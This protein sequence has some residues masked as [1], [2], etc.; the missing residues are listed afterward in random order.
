M[1]KHNTNHK[2]KLQELNLNLKNEIINFLNIKEIFSATFALNKNFHK[3]TNENNFINYI[4]LHKTELLE[5]INFSF[6][7]I[8]KIKSKFLN[9]S[10]NEI[11]LDQICSFLLCLKYKKEKN[12]ELSYHHK[13]LKILCFFIEFK[14]NFSFLQISSI[15][16]G[17]NSE[18]FKYFSHILFSVNKTL[19]FINLSMNL[20]RLTENNFKFFCEEF[21][22]NKNIQY[23][24]LSYNN[25]GSET[26]YLKYL[27][28]AIAE[29]TSLKSIDL[30][31]NN[32]GGK[33]EQVKYLSDAIEKNQTLQYIN[34]SYN[35]LLE[36]IENFKI[37]R[38]AL[39]KNKTL[40]GLD[41]NHNNLAMDTEKFYFFCDFILKNKTLQYLDLSYNHIGCKEENM[42]YLSRAIGENTA[43]KSVK[44]RS[45]IGENLLKISNCMSEALKL[46]KSIIIV[47]LS[48]HFDK[49]ME[50]SKIVDAMKEICE[51]Q[52]IEKDNQGKEEVIYKNEEGY[53]DK[54]R[55]LKVY[56]SKE[57]ID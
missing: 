15:N 33:E 54:I 55:K 6:E 17:E 10:L 37:I 23:I 7:K 42:N 48:W 35:N 26:F 41:L 47:Y 28:S 11:F 38:E 2:S 25:F 31:Y 44:L 34:F 14:S 3:L 43:L 45:R 4:I 5:E 16:I 52:V 13:T 39:E 27:S 12:M 46:N 9:F 51:F 29:N 18:N 40:L 36:K 53:E 30:T 50:I 49:I 21:S 56:V 24:N 22:K 8:N 32:I 57:I 19:Q 20:L 1:E